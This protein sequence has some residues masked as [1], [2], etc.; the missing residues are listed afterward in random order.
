[1]TVVMLGTV[2]LASLILKAGRKEAEIEP[3]LEAEQFEFV[4]VAAD[5]VPPL[6][7]T[8]DE[9]HELFTSNLK[10]EGRSGPDIAATLQRRE[11]RHRK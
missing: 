6:Q 4:A 3:E 7:P 2:G 1:M 8:S 9:A 5:D 10:V 11:P